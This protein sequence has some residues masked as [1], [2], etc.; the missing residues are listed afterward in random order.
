MCFLFSGFLY[1][2]YALFGP[3]ITIFM[4]FYSFLHETDLLFG[5][6]FLI[7]HVNYKFKSYTNQNFNEKITNSISYH[8]FH[9][10]G[11]CH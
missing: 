9:F 11:A 2:L 7:L 4:F 1:S 3:H 6:F 8:L 5:I 10:D